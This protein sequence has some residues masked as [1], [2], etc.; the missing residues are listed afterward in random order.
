[1]SKFSS[2]DLVQG[3]SLDDLASVFTIC[4]RPGETDADL[5]DRIMGDSWTDFEVEEEDDAR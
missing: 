1:M 4:R 3:K 5:R 2:W